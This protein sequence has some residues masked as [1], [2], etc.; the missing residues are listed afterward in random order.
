MARRTKSSQTDKEDVRRT[1]EGLKHPYPS[2]AGGG[3]YVIYADTKKQEEDHPRVLVLIFQ[4][5]YAAKR[6]ITVLIGNDEWE[7]GEPIGSRRGIVTTGG[8]RITAFGD[9]IDELMQYELSSQE[10]EWRDQAME[11]AALRL[12]LGTHWEGKKEEVVEE[13]VEDETTGEL[14]T[15]EVKVKKGKKE[16]KEKPEKKPKLD[17]SG[18]VTAGDLAARL[19]IEPRIFRGALRSLKKVKP[20]GGWLWSKDEAE[21]IFKEVEKELKKK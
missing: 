14:V 16:K 13:Q 19:K 1:V 18:M 3:K 9:A 17:K 7:E 12:R 15:R 2:K 5:A 8:V 10:A 6:F 20:E 4:E 11:T 21:A